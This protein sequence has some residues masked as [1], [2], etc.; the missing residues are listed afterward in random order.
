MAHHWQHTETND[1]KKKKKRNETLILYIFVCYYYLFA[2]ITKKPSPHPFLPSQKTINGRSLQLRPDLLLQKL[3]P[4]R[5][6]PK[7]KKKKHQLQQLFHIVRRPWSTQFL[8]RSSPSSSN[9]PLSQCH[10]FPPSMLSFGTSRKRISRYCRNSFPSARK[11]RSTSSNHKP[12]RTFKRKRL[13]AKRVAFCFPSDRNLA[14]SRNTRSQSA[15]LN[16]N[17]F[18]NQFTKSLSRFKSRHFR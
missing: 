13:P 10:P 12:L 17:L 5:T 16:R 14:R 15:R 3:S 8:N 4:L 18:N 2:Q 9:S 6:A 7:K 1:L 11:R